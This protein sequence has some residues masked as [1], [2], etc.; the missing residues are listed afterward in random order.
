MDEGEGGRKI[1]GKKGRGREVLRREKQGR[2]SGREEGR[3]KTG[4]RGKKGRRGREREIQI[5]RIRA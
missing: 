4:G 1:G 2:G 3:A 5:D